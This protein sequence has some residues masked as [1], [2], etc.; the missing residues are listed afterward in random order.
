MEATIRFAARVEVLA[1]VGRYGLRLPEEAPT[2]EAVEGVL[3]GFPFRAIVTLAT[4]GGRLIVFGAALL[5]AVRAE[6]GEVVD[7][8]ITRID[9]EE[10]VRLPADLA[11]A[12]EGAPASLAAWP[13]LTPMG[14]REWIRWVCS[15]KKAGTRAG[16]IEKACDM[17]AQGKRR[18]C[19]FPGVAFVTNGL[20][21][22]A[23]TWAP[24]P[25]G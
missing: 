16:R 24:L 10:E 23:E 6:P 25:R 9:A 13:G 11:A 4:G 7:V 19:C 22:P 8:E 18:P 21:D 1:D 5:G 17:L 3:A 2:A 14:R 12:L 15:P 20:V